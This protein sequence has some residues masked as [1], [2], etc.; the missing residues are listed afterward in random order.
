MAEPQQ[1]PRAVIRAPGLFLG[2]PLGVPLYVSP[3]WLF[4]AIYIVVAFQP[5]VHEFVH[6]LSTQAEY[7]VAFASA[8][9]L[10]IS[11]IAHELAHAAVG[12]GLGLSVRRMT[13]SFIAGATEVQ[14][15][16]T[17]GREYLVA[18]AGPLS[19]LL[20]AGVSAG[21]LPLTDPAGAARYL[22]AYVAYVNLLVGGLNLLPGLPLDGGRVVRA[23]VWRITSEKLTGTRWAA[24]GGYATAAAIAG[25]ALYRA[26]VSV[27]PTGLSVDFFI[28]VLIAA[29][30]LAGAR[31][32]LTFAEVQSRLPAVLAARLVRRSVA[33]SD[34]TPL[35]EALRRAHEAGAYGIVTVDSAGD[36]TGVVNEAAVIATPEQRRPWVP[37][38]AFARSLEPGLKL[39]A[40]LSGQELIEALRATPASEYV[41]V[42]RG[43]AIMGVLAATD[44]ARMLD[45]PRAQPATR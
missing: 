13:I 14:E 5:V 43:G 28:L 8:L 23:A 17:A 26:A 35:G 41:V 3:S 38:S 34:R 19:S 40:E 15:A 31:Q 30:V 11:V 21:F 4:V 42:D 37:V 20:L 25:Y 7:A 39:A 10:L 24:Y 36:P 2:R 1:R 44:V 12:R 6:G 9:L 29:F 27:N 33:V 45:S 16:Q 32:S 22:V 18:V